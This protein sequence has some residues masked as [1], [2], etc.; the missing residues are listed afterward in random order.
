ML[1][2]TPPSRLLSCSRRVTCT[3]EDHEIVDAG[4]QPRRFRIVDEVGRGDDLAL[5]RAQPRQRLVAADLALRQ[6]DYRLQMEV[7]PV[8]PIA[9]STVSVLIQRGFARGGSGMAVGSGSGAGAAMRG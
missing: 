7:D 9:C 8:P 6:S 1:Q 2:N 4:H 5:V 3:A